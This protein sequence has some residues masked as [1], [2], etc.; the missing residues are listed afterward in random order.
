MVSGDKEEGSTDSDSAAPASRRF[1][2]LAAG[3]VM[4]AINGEIRLDG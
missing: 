1:S 3:A 4:L 2:S